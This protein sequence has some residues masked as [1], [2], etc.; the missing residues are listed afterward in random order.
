[1]DIYEELKQRGA[2]SSAR[3]FS[4]AFLGR[5]PNHYCENRD[6]GFTTETLVTLHHR[7]R[8]HGFNDLAEEVACIV[9]DLPS[10]RGPHT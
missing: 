4:K 8:E 9:F 1:M 7:L 3:F 6:N 10:P 5:A 2:V